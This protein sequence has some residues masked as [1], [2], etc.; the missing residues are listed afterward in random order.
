MIVLRFFVFIISLFFFLKLD[1]FGSAVASIEFDST[2]PDI[3]EFLKKDLEIFSLSQDGISHKKHLKSKAKKTLD[4]LYRKLQSLGYFDAKIT[5]KY[6]KELSLNVVFQIVLGQAFLTNDCVL[7]VDQSDESLRLAD[8][9]KKKLFVSGQVYTFSQ[10]MTLRQNIEK[11]IKEQGYAFAEVDFPDLKIDYER[12]AVFVIYALNLKE[13]YR[14]GN[15]T[16]KGIDKFDVEILKRRISWEGNHSFQQSLLK[17]TEERIADLQVF[18][19]VSLSPKARGEYVDIEGNFKFAPP[20]TISAMLR[21]FTTEGFGGVFSWRHRNLFD[22]ADQFDFLAKYSQLEQGISFGFF[23]QDFQDIADLKSFFKTDLS[24]RIQLPVQ[25]ISFTNS[26][27]L[28]YK[29]SK[30]LT[31]FQNCSLETENY[32]NIDKNWYR[33]FYFPLKFK[34]DNRNSTSNPKKGHLGIFQ[35]TPYFG[36]IYKTIPWELSMQATGY[37]DF[38]PV[39]FALN[40]TYS[41]FFNVDINTLALSKQY[42]GGGDSSVRGYSY[43]S[44]SPGGVEEDNNTGNWVAQNGSKNKIEITPEIRVAV[45]D[46]FGVIFFSD[47]GIFSRS[48][49]IWSNLHMLTS[50][51]YESFD[52]IVAGDVGIGFNYFSMIGPIRLDFALPWVTRS[53]NGQVI[54]SSFQF[55]VRFGQGF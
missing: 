20:R 7:R 40:M 48:N 52:G 21:Y 6:S 39:M 5:L 12:K 41:Q 26:I 8:E 53:L 19:L 43:Q 44:L 30:E 22:H 4:E 18:S 55:Y 1:V 14:F 31:L 32:Y 37:L 11:E 9:V 36:E 15:V 23:R 2:N 51:N 24:K 46:V 3:E 45:N 42:F 50:D 25:N 49:N 33:T 17:T 38:S 13:K 16:F 28:E 10:Y 29:I 27:G 47:I 34:I 35:I 54:D